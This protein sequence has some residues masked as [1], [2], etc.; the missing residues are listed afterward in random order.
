MNNYK[1]NGNKYIIH[2]YNINNNNV[3]QNNDD[4]KKDKTAYDYMSQIPNNTKRKIVV[5]DLEV[6]GRGDDAR[7]LEIDAREMFKGKLTKK[8]DFINFSNLKIKCQKH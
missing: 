6:F 1:M 2:Q 3:N 4:N 8:K 5:L 7:I